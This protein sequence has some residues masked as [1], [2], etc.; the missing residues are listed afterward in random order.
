MERNLREELKELSKLILGGPSRYQKLLK[1][2]GNVKSVIGG[3]QVLVKNYFTPESLLE[4]L[5]NIKKAHEEKL[6]I[7][8]IQKT[9]SGKV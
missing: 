3:K 2:G 9:S 1:N 8:E 4:E 7:E 5:R 6:A